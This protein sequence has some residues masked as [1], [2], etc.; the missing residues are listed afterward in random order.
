EEALALVLRGA[1]DRASLLMRLREDDLR[2]ALRRLDRLGG[3]LL[4]GD[5]RRRE[6]RFALLDLVQ[7]LLDVFELVGELAA[8]APN[9]LEAVG[10]V[11]EAHI[12]FR[13]P[14]AAQD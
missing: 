3:R 1:R 2:L 9:V 10:D 5:Q 7:M 4:G 14:V 6:Q 11:G 13:P 12:G 8:L